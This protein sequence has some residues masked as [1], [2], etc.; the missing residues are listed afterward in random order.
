[1]RKSI[2]MRIPSLLRA[3]GTVALAAILCVDLA[4]AEPPPA[5]RGWR[6]GPPA[7]APRG[8]FFGV[9]AIPQPI[10]NPIPIPP[11][12]PNQPPFPPQVLI[13]YSVVPGTSVPGLTGPIDRCL[14][15]APVQGDSR[16]LVTA[17]NEIDPRFIHESSVQGLPAR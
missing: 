4:A 2:P 6:P 1:M 7:V 3:P 11:G 16:F 5:P 15:V 10:P 14:V 12:F 13:P 8:P 17:S 9:P